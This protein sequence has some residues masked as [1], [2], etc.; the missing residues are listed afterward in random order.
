[1]AWIR[2]NPNP[3]NRIVG[4]CAVR[5]V[6]KALDVGWETAHVMLD[7]NSYMMGDISNSNAVIGSVLR[8]NGFYRAVIPDSCPDCYT[9]EDFAQEH[10]DGVYVLGT[11]THVVTVDS[12][13]IYDTWDSSGEVPIY[14]WYQKKEDS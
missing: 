10:P 9:A 12:G 4:D 7:F 11:G 13:D 6:A 3:V 8:Q 14:Y 2:W 5:A 1:M